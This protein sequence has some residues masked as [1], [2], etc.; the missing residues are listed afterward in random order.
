M[1]CFERE[2]NVQPWSEFSKEVQTELNLK[3]F[4]NHLP[5]LNS[6]LKKYMRD[7]NVSSEVFNF[8]RQIKPEVDTMGH[9]EYKVRN[10]SHHNSFIKC[11]LRL[12]IHEQLKLIE[13]NADRL[14][15]LITQLHWRLNEGGNF[16]IYE[17]GV[18]DDG[19]ILGL[20]K[21]EMERSLETLERMCQ[22]LGAK[23]NLVKMFKVECQFED[24]AMVKSEGA[25]IKSEEV[26]RGTT[27]DLVE[28]TSS[29]T[30]SLSL[31]RELFNSIQEP[32]TPPLQS[33]PLL[34]LPLKDVP[35]SDPRL[36][37]LHHLRAL[38]FFY[39]SEI[40]HQSAFTN[41][42][43]KHKK[44]KK[45]KPRKCLTTI[46]QSSSLLPST[47]KLMHG[48]PLLPRAGNIATEDKF[49]FEILIKRDSLSG[50]GD[51]LD[52][53]TDFNLSL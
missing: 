36:L 17:I 12:T 33:L 27:P 38:P 21:F 32:L 39:S 8:P 37:D 41:L 6:L 28:S 22:A 50:E 52:F 45:F 24:F 46:S 13:P 35:L 4:S 16:A 9:I 7:E 30:L 19:I 25:M 49:I 43:P 26:E 40:F 42:K 5:L 53:E 11:Y 14:E 3:N 44:K 18:R 20:T 48:V 15:K 23:M 51:F 1:F 29:S 10:L 47:T 34:N 31:P 2:R